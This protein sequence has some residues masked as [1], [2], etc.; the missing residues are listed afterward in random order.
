[1][2]SGVSRMRSKISRREDSQMSASLAI[3]E[4]S[5]IVLSL[6]RSGKTQSELDHLKGCM[7]ALGLMA[8]CSPGNIE[9]GNRR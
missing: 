8:A 3:C 5:A 6:R 9:L 7:V 1:M 2:M 4:C